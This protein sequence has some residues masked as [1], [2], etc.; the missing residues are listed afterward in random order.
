MINTKLLKVKYIYIEKLTDF[1]TKLQL[2]IHANNCGAISNWDS[3]ADEQI[4]IIP[5]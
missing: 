2:Q 4:I 3:M 5:G 1:K